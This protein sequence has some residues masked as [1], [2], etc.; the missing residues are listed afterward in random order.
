MTDENTTPEQQRPTRGDGVRRE[1]DERRPLPEPARRGRYREVWVGLFV[2]LGVT[3][4]LVALFALTDPG[5]F[6][7]RYNLTLLVPDAAGIRTGDP[8]RMRGVNIGRVRGFAIRGKDVAIR[9]ELS[10]DYPIPNDSY[11]VLQSANVFGEMAA[12]VVPGKSPQPLNW[13]DSIQGRITQSLLGKADNLAAEAS[14]TL[15]RVQELLS[16]SVVDNIEQS[17][18]ELVTLLKGLGVTTGQLQTLTASLNQSAHGVQRALQ[19]PELEQTVNRLAEL[20]RSLEVVAQSLERSSHSAEMVLGRMA[21]GEGSLGRLAQDEALYANATAAT[22]RLGQAADELARLA[23][24]I[25]KNPKRYLK[26]SVF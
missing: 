10:R 2:M 15:G 12:E 13:G 22:L 14:T 20:S 18:D 23:E 4:V 1:R 25:R 11:V 7:Q 8:V 6:R 16:P 17:T 21:R 3:A 9:L 5:M 26:F 19:G 24:D